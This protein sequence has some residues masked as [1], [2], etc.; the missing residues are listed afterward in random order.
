[1]Q[2]DSS[3]GIDQFKM[4]EERGED[5]DG[6]VP[7]SEKSE[8]IENYKDDSEKTDEKFNVDN[9]RSE[10]SE[11]IENYKDD[12][13]KTDEKFNVDNKEFITDVLNELKLNNSLFNIEMLEE[14]VRRID[15]NN[16]ELKEKSKEAICQRLPTLLMF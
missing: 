3:E 9:T 2:E 15:F 4:T 16:E 8:K 13:E 5:N 7:R 12:S 10:K 14:V 11:K 6:K 1:M